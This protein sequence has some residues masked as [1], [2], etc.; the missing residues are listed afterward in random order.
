MGKIATGICK[1]LKYAC[2]SITYIFASFFP[3][4]GVGECWFRGREGSKDQDECLV[5]L[6]YLYELDLGIPGLVF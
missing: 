1:I 5:F 3:R 2:I 4:A 6:G